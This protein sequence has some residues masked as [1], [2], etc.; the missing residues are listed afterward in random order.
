MWQLPQAVSPVSRSEYPR[1][2]TAAAGG[3]SK[4]S[5]SRKMISSSVH[6]PS[7]AMRTSTAIARVHERL[8]TIHPLWAGVR[9]LTDPDVRTSC[10]YRNLDAVGKSPSLRNKCEKTAKP[11]DIW[12]HGLSRIGPSS[13]ETSGGGAVI[14][15][16]FPTGRSVAELPGWDSNP[17]PSD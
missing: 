1:N 6:A 12:L 4:S 17:R 5:R 14:R 8:L 9:S 11:L 7:E 3:S 13:P 10:V 15:S 2:P 16:R